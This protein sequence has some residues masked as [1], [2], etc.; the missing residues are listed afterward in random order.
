MDRVDTLDM[1]HHISYYIHMIHEFRVLSNDLNDGQVRISKF[2]VYRGYLH[3]SWIPEINIVI[4]GI[5][6][7]CHTISGFVYIAY[8]Q[9]HININKFV[10]LADV[11]VKVDIYHGYD[12]Y[13]FSSYT[14]D[15]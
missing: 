14:Y 3:V 12:S 5:F 15:T 9:S 8:H 13:N 7:L 1:F 6:Y 11:V 2:H 4:F 10:I